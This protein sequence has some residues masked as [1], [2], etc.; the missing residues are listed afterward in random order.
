MPLVR[1]SVRK[2]KSAAYLAAVGDAIHQA[3]V[4]TINVPPED[5]FQIFSEHSPQELVY[6]E[7]YLGI[8]RTDALVVIQITLNAGR[9]PEMKK[10]LYRTLADKLARN[11][12]LRQADVLVNLVEVPRENWSFGLGEMSYAPKP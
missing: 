8:R 4:E 9:T 5:R 10:A 2:G 6:D 12:G 11:P 1:V 7:G 3:M